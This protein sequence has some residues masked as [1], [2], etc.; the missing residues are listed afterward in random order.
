MKLL[1]R[2][3]VRMDVPRSR[4]DQSELRFTQFNQ[5]TI[6]QS[7]ETLGV[8]DVF[9]ECFCVHKCQTSHKTT[10]RRTD[11]LT[12]LIKIFLFQVQDKAAIELI[13]SSQG[14]G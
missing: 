10:V 9:V 7:L 14:S 5:S 4:V 6:K 2:V 8:F 12:S 11:V 13:W 3:V 1:F